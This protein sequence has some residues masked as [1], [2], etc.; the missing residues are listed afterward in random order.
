MYLLELKN[1]IFVPLL[2]SWLTL[3]NPKDGWIRSIG[4]YLFFSAALE[5]IA[6]ITSFFCTSNHNLYYIA[7]YI[8]VFLIGRILS[9][10][11]YKR[12]KKVKPVLLTIMLGSMIIFSLLRIAKLP[13]LTDAL[14]QNILVHGFIILIATTY[15]FHK[16]A[17]VSDVK[18]LKTAEFWAL[19]ALLLYYTCSGPSLALSLYLYES[20]QQ[21]SDQLMYINDFLFL[22]KYFLILVSINLFR[23][24]FEYVSTGK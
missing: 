20:N 22:L 1:L 21:L 16:Q 13:L 8:D 23:N 17:Q 12:K 24:Q 9:S 19:S 3:R 5:L 7:S 4:N 15:T 6:W 10:I 18:I 2:L 14:T 11:V